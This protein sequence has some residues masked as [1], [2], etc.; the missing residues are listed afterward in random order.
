MDINNWNFRQNIIK[1]YERKARKRHT[2]CETFMSLDVKNVNEWLIGGFQLLTNSCNC[3]FFSPQ[4]KTS[5]L[6]W[7]T[8]IHANAPHGNHNARASRMAFEN[9]M[10]L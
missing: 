9:E 5:F 1:T 7:Y 4:S 6:F 8:L 2:S 10:N 3:T